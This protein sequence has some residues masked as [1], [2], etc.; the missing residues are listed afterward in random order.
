[1]SNLSWSV[2]CG[3]LGKRH[4]NGGVEISHLV[5]LIGGGEVTPAVKQQLGGWKRKFNCEALTGKY[6]K[7]G[8]TDGPIATGRALTPRQL[9]TSVICRDALGGL[10]IALGGDSPGRGRKDNP[11]DLG[12]LV[13]DIDLEEGDDT[14]LAE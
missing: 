7:K 6:H 14:P 10:L 12:D 8:G 1:M 9:K 11:L 4:L 13:D 3:E 5:E 2:V